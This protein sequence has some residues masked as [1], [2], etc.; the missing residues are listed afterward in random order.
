[1]SSEYSKR[2]PNALDDL[3]CCVVAPTHSPKITDLVV[4]QL[5]WADRGV[6]RRQIEGAAAFEIKSGVAPMTGQGAVIDTPRLS[7]KPCADTDC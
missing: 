4:A 3:K 1:M 6:V 2:L 7:E 5:D